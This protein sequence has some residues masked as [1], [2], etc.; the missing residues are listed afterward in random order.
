MNYKCNIIIGMLCVTAGFSVIAG[1]VDKKQSTQIRIACVGDSITEGS[2]IRDAK[3]NGY[4]AQLGKLLGQKYDV[5][6]FGIRMRVVMK[7]QY[8]SYWKS[9]EFK[10]A[11]AFL[12][13]VVIIMLGTNDAKDVYWKGGKRDFIPDYE[14]LIKV[15][16]NLKSKPKVYVCF[17]PPIFPEKYGITDTRI[18]TEIIPMIKQ[19]AKNAGVK[20][21]DMYKALKGKGEMFPDKIHPNIEGAAV[22]AKTVYLILKKRK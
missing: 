22:M 16:Q 15:F 11:K 2:G 14:A 17:P 9:E 1:A 7:K 12:P 10:A 21:I 18:K 4:P 8:P 6:N 13:N 3:I 20:A 19:I 5:R